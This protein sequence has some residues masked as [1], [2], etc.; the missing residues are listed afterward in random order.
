MGEVLTLAGRLGVNVADIEIAHSLEGGAGVLVLVVAAADADGYEAGLHDA[1]YRTARTE[2][3]MTLPTEIST[4]G[5]RPL[6]GRL[7]LPGDKSISHRAL[8]FA[9]LADGRSTIMHLA[10]GADVHATRSALEQLGVHVRE[11]GETVVVQSAGVDA[12]TEPV[13]V[14]DC[15]N[16]GTTMRILAGPLAGRPF[17]SV[18]TGDASLRQRPMARVVRPLPRDGRRDR[19]P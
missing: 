11:R 8:M 18:L 17:L 6:R 12:W 10:T 7:R 15:E 2:L 9:A 13:D 1:G 16:S 3:S 19:R 4:G 5:V 14:L